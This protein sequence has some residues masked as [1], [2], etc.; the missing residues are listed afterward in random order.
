MRRYL[1]QFGKRRS[2]AGTRC[3]TSRLL[4]RS[5]RAGCSAEAAGSVRQQ[6]CADRPPSLAYAT[7]EAGVGL[8][9]GVRELKQ[10][11]L[12]LFVAKAALGALA[13]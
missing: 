5:T 11:W 10:V 9:W 13:R 12:G 6:R 3:R 7:S 4:S 1:A 2:R 8:G